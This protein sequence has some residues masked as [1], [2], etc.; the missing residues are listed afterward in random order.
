MLEGKVTVE[1]K[2]R[3]ENAAIG[4]NTFTILSEEVFEIYD[5]KTSLLLHSARNSG[6]EEVQSFAYLPSTDH[7]IVLHWNSNNLII[8]DALTNQQITSVNIAEYAPYAS[9]E[10]D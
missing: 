2:S 7:L 9:L 3:F 8:L 6:G 5:I 1:S 10:L 4:E